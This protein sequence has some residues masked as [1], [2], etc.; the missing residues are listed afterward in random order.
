MT[1]T[2]GGSAA[3][4]V[5]DASGNVQGGRTVTI[6]TSRTGGS[7]VTDLLT[8]DGQALPGYLTQDAGGE[9]IK[10]IR[11]TDELVVLWADSGMDYRW[12]MAPIEAVA[13]VAEAEQIANT[14]KTAADQATAAAAD[15]QTQL[16]TIQSQLDPQVTDLDTFKTQVPTNEELLFSTELTYWN[17][18][19]DPTTA[20]IA[21]ILTAP[22]DMD[23]LS[24]ALAFDYYNLAA[25]D[26]SYWSAQVRF[27]DNSGWSTV[28]TRSTQATGTNANGAI[29][30]RKPWTFDGAAW[31]S[32]RLTAG[33]LLGIAFTPTGSPGALNIPVNITV[34]YAPA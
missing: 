30:A 14:A 4:V 8:W 7:Q 34:R 21:S 22:F 28:A 6:W 16:T 19:E 25:N 26:T 27:G 1:A 10:F 33:K 23:I 11:D 20:F 29:T 31:S 12:P 17:A 15:L 9:P 24:V 13:K 5:T 18:A 2:Y 3:D 32:R